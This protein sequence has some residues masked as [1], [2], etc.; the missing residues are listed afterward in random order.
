M[1]KYLY[2]FSL[3][4]FLII[5]LFTSCSQEQQLV[6]I[7]K[8]D[9][10]MG[11]IIQITVLDSSKQDVNKAIDQSFQEINRVGNLFYKG[12]PESPVYKF[13]HRTGNSVKMPQEVFDLILRADRISRKTQ[14]SFDMTIEKLLPLYDF[15]G[16]SLRPPQ[17]KLVDSL[18]QYV[19]YNHLEFDSSTN[20]ITSQREGLSL[21]T[22]G[23]A[24]GFAVDRAIYILDSIGV[25]GALVNAGGDLRVLPRSSKKW[26]V[27]IQNP[28]QPNQTIG[29]ITLD[30]GAVTTSGDYEQYFNYNGKRYHHIINPK[31]GYPARASRSVTVIAPTT[32]LADALATGLFIL[33]YE[34]GLKV[35][36]SFPN[37]EAFWV[38]SSGGYHKS[39][40]FDRYLE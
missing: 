31:T 18:I 7:S 12:N 19:G 30:S 33:G 16:D 29:I 35:L 8:T 27:G 6:K 38:D 40:G 9:F 22:G 17:K 1:Q 28:R 23:N 2:R 11:T 21:A 34:E 32:E 3:I 26:R 24:K 4:F 39:S 14:G 5:L 15:S 36:D 20:T 25:S 37:C 13:N 10:A